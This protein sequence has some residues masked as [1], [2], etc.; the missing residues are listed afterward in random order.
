MIASSKRI[1]F[2]G[3]QGQDALFLI[4]VQICPE[5]RDGRSHG[6]EHHRDPAPVYA[7]QEQ[8]HE[9]R[10]HYQDRGTQIRLASNQQ[11]RD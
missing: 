6:T 9:T 3:E 7:C 8:R 5:Y 10:G 1:G 2:R 11:G 4:V